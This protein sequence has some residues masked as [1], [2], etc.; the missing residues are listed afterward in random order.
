MQLAPAQLDFLRK[1]I[2][3]FSQEKWIVEP[4]GLAGSD[5]R[6]VRVCDATR[7]RSFILI[8]WDS[9]DKDWERFIGIQKEVSGLVSF[10]PQVFA[11]DAGHGLILEEDLGL[12]TLHSF[13]KQHQDQPAEIEAIYRKTIDAL[14]EW[15]TMPVT[16]SQHLAARVMDV[17]MFMWESEYFSIHCVTEFCGN[18]KMLVPEWLAERQSIADDLAKYSQVC[19]HRDFQSENIMVKEGTIRFVDFQGARLGPAGYDLASLL[20]DPYSEIINATMVVKLVEYYRSR[21]PRTF[22]GKGFVLC[23]ISRLM[24]ALGAYANLSL[25]KGKDRYRQYVPVALHRLAE[26]LQDYKG[27]PCLKEVVAACQKTVR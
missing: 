6:F 9:A 17:E 20:Y 11:V 26:V 27:L 4:A 12:V 14:I 24:Q 10:L 7:H 1:N 16:A 5:R 25:H 15:Q 21:S 8:L 22:N 13:C 18:E 2:A 19:I 3:G 23:A